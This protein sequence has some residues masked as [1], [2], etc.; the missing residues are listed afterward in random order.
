MK[1][2]HPQNPLIKTVFM[3]QELLPNPVCLHTLVR[4][5]STGS[6]HYATRR[7]SFI[8]NDVPSDLY[9]STDE[10]MLAAVFGSLLNTVITHS[11]YCCIRITAKNYGR[12][13][14]FQL[15]ETHR[16]NSHAFTGNLRQIQLLA[17]KIGG[18]VS[19]SNNR[20]EATTI[21]FSFVNNT[22]LAA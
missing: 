18:S 22:P 15:K 10:H 20:D 8:I 4:R 12:V 13:V 19:V 17:E 2:G 11:E 14:L 9:A 6:I 16:S 3:K 21:V 5:I 1:S 7:N